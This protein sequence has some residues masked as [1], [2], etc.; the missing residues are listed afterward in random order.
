[1]RR[2]DDVYLT[3]DGTVL[4]SDNRVELQELM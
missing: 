1:V 4:L 3:P 2:G